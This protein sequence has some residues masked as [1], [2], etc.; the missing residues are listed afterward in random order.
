MMNLAMRRHLFCQAVTAKAIDLEDMRKDLALYAFDYQSLYLF[1]SAEMKVLNL[2]AGNADKVMVMFFIPAEVIV[3]LSVRMEHTRYDVAFMKFIEDTVH[4]RKADALE[5][6]LH[7]LPD[8]LRAQIHLFVIEDLKKCDPL[9]RGLQA[10]A[11][12]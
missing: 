5:S 12:Q 9:R 10:E 7:L 3:K 4:G 1:F 11:F 8:R 6:F 2:I